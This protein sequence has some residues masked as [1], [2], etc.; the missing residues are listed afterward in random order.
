MYSGQYEMWGPGQGIGIGM[1]VLMMIFWV[2]VGAAIIYF[3]RH[4]SH[5]H[6][7]HHTHAPVTASG[8]SPVDILKLRF[9]RGEIDEDEFAKRLQRLQGEQ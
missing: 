3:V 6:D 7:V 1:F 9:A 4:S 5:G 2:A 8:T